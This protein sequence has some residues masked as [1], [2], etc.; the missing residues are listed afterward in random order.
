MPAQNFP[1]H[2]TGR[3]TSQRSLCRHRVYAH[4][5]S[6]TNLRTYILDRTRYMPH[7]ETYSRLDLCRPI[8]SRGILWS[9][10]RLSRRGSTQAPAVSDHHLRPDPVSL[11]RW[12]RQS[13]PPPTLEISMRDIATAGERTLE[14]IAKRFSQI[15]TCAARFSS[16]L[17]LILLRL[18]S[19]QSPQDRL[20]NV[21]PIAGHL[22]C[23]SGHQR[24]YC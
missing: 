23:S 6:R 7:C 5:H 22:A 1:R 10:S 14:H 4:L 24:R 20:P 2:P 15:I 18:S 13:L 3:R 16:H 8:R 19:Y 17:G 9:R 12:G 21:R 11:R